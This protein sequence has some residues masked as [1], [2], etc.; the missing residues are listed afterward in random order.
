MTGSLIINN[1]AGLM[2]FTSPMVIGVKRPAAS[3]WLYSLQTLILVLLLLTLVMGE[4]VRMISS[5]IFGS[6]PQ[7]VSRGERGLLT[8]LPMDVL[9][10]LMLIMGTSIPHPVIQILENAASV[11]LQRNSRAVQPHYTWPW[12]SGSDNTVS[13]AGRRAVNTSSGEKSD[14]R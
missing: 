4:L 11:V 10:V 2:M 7:Q 9:L 6:A 13:I 1:L 8:T 12:A 3:C 14:L 5:I